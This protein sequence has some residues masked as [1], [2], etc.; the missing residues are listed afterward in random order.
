MAVSAP[1]PLVS[2]GFRRLFFDG[3]AAE[4]LDLNWLRRQRVAPVRRGPEDIVLAMERPQDTE[5]ARAVQRTTRRRPVVIAATPEEVDDLLDRAAD[6]P[7]DVTRQLA[8]LAP[9]LGLLGLSPLPATL[10]AAGLFSEALRQATADGLASEGDLR[11]A[12]A[13]AFGLPTA[14]PETV[15]DPKPGLDRLVPED[16]RGEGV[17][18]IAVTRGHLLVA[19][20]APPDHRVVRRIEAFSGFQVAPLVVSFS[21]LQAL[22]TPLNAGRDTG[23]GVGPQ[24]AGITD[25]LERAVQLDKIRLA[26]LEQ[27]RLIAREQRQP[28]ETVVL[29]LGII[30]AEALAL[31]RWQAA[32]IDTVEGVPTPDSGFLARVPGTLAR[33]LHALPLQTQRGRVTCLMADPGDTA[34]TELLSALLGSEITPI[35]LPETS[36]L[37]AIGAAYAEE[38]SWA[39][40]LEPA[41]VAA[42]LEGDVGPAEAQAI[43][44]MVPTAD[45]GHLRFESAPP[46]DCPEHVARELGIVP[47]WQA[48][49]VLFGAVSTPRWSDAAAAL[50]AETR[51]HLRPVLADPMDV[52]DA[53]DR[54]YSPRVYSLP[55][56]YPPFEQ[57]LAR[58]HDVPHRALVAARRAIVSDGSPTDIAL[59]RAGVLPPETLAEAYSAYLKIPRAAI[60]FQERV[61]R[62]LDPLGREIERFRMVD[63]VDSAVASRLDLDLARELS[64]LPYLQ[65]RRGIHVAVADPLGPGLAEIARRLGVSVVPAVAPRPEIE[66]AIRRTL[67]NPSIGDGLLADGLITH[68]QLSRAL[69]LSRQS[70]VRLGT[71]LTTLDIVSEEQL[72]SFLGEQFGLP[73]F[74]IEPEMIDAQVVQLLPEDLQRDRLIIPIGAD[75]TSVTIASV[76]PMDEVLLEDLRLRLAREISPVLTTEKYLRRCLDTFYRDLYL[77]RAANELLSRSPEDSASHVLTDRQKFIFVGLLLV[78]TGGLAANHIVFLQVLCTVLTT[79]VLTLSIY[80]SYLI[81]RALA[82][83]LEVPITAEQVAALEERDLPVYT[84]LIPM[85]REAEVLPGLTRGVSRLDYPKTKLD[86][87]LLL[88]E[89]DLETQEAA[90]ALNLPSYFQ[91]VVVPHGM[92]KGKP[93]ACNYGLIHAKG[94][95]VVIYDAEDVPDPDQLKKAILAFQ[96]D[97]VLACVQSKL[98][99]YNRNQN[100]LTRWFTAEY[101]VWFDL[102]LP[103][104]D[105]TNAPIP[106]GG[107]SNHFRTDQL[108]EIGGWDPYNVTEDADL[109]LRLFVRGWRTAVID[110]TTYEEANSA[111]FNWIRQRSRWVK[112][113]IQTWLVRMRHPVALFRMLGPYGFFSFQMVV[114]GTFGSFLVNPFFWML[115]LLWFLTR[116]G[117]IEQLF[118][119]VVFLIG[120]VGL[121]VGNF[122]FTYLNVAGCLRRQYYELVKYALLSPVYWALMSIAAWKGF[123]QLFYRPFYWEKTQHGLYR[124]P[125]ETE[126]PE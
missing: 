28:L 43:A 86:V 72:Y 6:R 111:L 8:C 97:S 14:R 15:P 9:A 113:Y 120:A 96:G 50:L 7:V 20:G 92:P 47:L 27:A 64:A 1:E 93:K 22:R 11:L 2:L 118:P 5:A 114:L 75:A 44:L 33:H 78:L 58:R 105:A 59:V 19:V 39:G 88:E 37:A 91:V 53:L 31:L 101:S 71:A 12:V 63:P 57:W 3:D 82:H 55:E 74:D 21:R 122:A 99:Y 95:Y 4:G 25:A 112:G 121:Y 45:L 100:L 81:Y 34:G 36:I 48:G 80:K 73:F 87:K 49:R 115:T 23:S 89:D 51:L 126:S 38:G 90:H 108:R 46:T 29:N 60:A 119:G 116:W 56:Q 30:D 32:G 70:G 41:E 102:L 66:D 67:G 117:L 69:Q 62:A 123:L 125:V 83:V 79:F 18:P 42:A 124:G 98:N 65:N 52:E 17:V 106:L 26:A 76:E 16:L 109:G 85:Y 10:A 24:P 54:L 107:T 104:L 61:E 110:S 103:G 77:E 40:P 35:Y 13:L 94:E 68:E 84:I